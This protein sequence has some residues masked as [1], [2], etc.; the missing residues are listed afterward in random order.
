VLVCHYPTLSIKVF[1]PMLVRTVLVSGMRIR[2]VLTE[3]QVRL[4]KLLAPVFN[5]S[6]QHG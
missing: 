1:L 3:E 6:L 2:N 5:H 4:L